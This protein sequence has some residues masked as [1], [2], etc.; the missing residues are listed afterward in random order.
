MS[1]FL[2]DICLSL[3]ISLSCSFVIVSGFFCGGLFETFIIALAILLR[4]KPPVASASFFFFVMFILSSVQSGL[5]FWSVNHALI[6]ENS[7]SK[8]FKNIKFLGEMSSN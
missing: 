6:Y 3:G 1:S 4:I 8:V 2:E 7:E 5:E